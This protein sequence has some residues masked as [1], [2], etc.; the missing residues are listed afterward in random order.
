MFSVLCFILRAEIQAG[1]LDSSGSFASLSLDDGNSDDE[2]LMPVKLTSMSTPVTTPSLCSEL[3][4]TLV[5]D[6]I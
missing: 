6:Y 2:E 1:K 4:K 3:R 5:N